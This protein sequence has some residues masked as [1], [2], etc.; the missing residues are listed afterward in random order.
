MHHRIL[1]LLAFLLLAAF[2]LIFFWHVP[3]VDLGILFAITLAMAAYDF[4]FRS[5]SDDH[6]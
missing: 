3:R 4:L 5:H 2:L 6:S 1:A